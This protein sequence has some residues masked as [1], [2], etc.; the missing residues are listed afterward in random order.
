M[1]TVSKP[2]H[3]GRVVRLELEHRLALS[4][5]DVQ[6]VDAARELA[7]FVDVEPLRIVRPPGR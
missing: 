1:V 7:R 6:G 5:D 4:T 2:L 3:A